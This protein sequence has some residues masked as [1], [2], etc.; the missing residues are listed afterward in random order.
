MRLFSA[1][2]LSLLMCAPAAHAQAC[3]ETAT[4]ALSALGI[5]AA[6]SGDAAM[7]FRTRNLTML[8]Q[9]V[10]YAVVSWWEEDD[11]GT[12]V[13]KVVYRLGS[14]NRA[15]GQDYPANLR[16]AFDRAYPDAYCGRDPM[17]GCRSNGNGGALQGARLT[18][19][20]TA[21][22]YDVEGPGAALYQADEALDDRWPALL[23]CDY[24]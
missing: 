11:G 15:S 3:P 18:D 13:E 5:D 7:A 4:A 2:L 21:S 10:P 24:L 12:A 6:P 1:T 9:S 19:W 8:G 20:R 17:L 16:Q 23:V 22:V 14:I